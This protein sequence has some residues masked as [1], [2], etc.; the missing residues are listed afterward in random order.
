[1]PELVV[2]P[3]GYRAPQTKR[4]GHADDADIECYLPVAHE[5]AQVDFESD[6]EEKEHKTK[7]SDQIQLGH[8][9]I[10][11]DVGF[12]SGD[13]SHGGWTQQDASNDLG[14]NARLAELVQGPF[15]RATETDDD[16]DLICSLGRWGSL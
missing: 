5:I 16:D 14:D 6:D 12:E 9:G 15:E 2:K 4:N 7:V 1:M 13:A 8:G 3:H 11:E 10:R